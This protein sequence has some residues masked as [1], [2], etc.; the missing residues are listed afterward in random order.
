MFSNS[1]ILLVLLFI[2][3]CASPVKITKIADKYPKKYQSSYKNS[4]TIYFSLDEI[5]YDFVIIASVQLDNSHIYGN[6]NYDTSMKNHLLNRI[7]G[8]GADAL[9]YNQELSD[10]NYTYFHAISY[11]RNDNRNPFFDNEE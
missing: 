5:E 6:H 10:S 7:K 4:L 3:S 1:F 9:I 8:I 11:I 2:V